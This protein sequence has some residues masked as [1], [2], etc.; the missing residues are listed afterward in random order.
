MALLL[1]FSIIAFLVIVGNAW[2]LLC[3][4]R[5]PRLPRNGAAEALPGRRGLKGLLQHLLSAAEP[6][7]QPQPPPGRRGLMYRCKRGARIPWMHPK[8]R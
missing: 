2:L 7:P 6:L 4:A 1:I 3:T 8:I 5:K